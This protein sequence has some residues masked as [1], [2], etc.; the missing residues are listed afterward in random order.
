MFDDRKRPAQTFELVQAAPANSCLRRDQLVISRI[1]STKYI[2]EVCANAFI[3]FASKIAKPFD[4]A[5][6]Q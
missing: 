5:N 1:N 3:A 6:V 2:F 4:V